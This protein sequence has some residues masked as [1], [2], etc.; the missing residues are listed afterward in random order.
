MALAVRRGNLRPPGVWARRQAGRAIAA[1]TRA[2][3]PR[4]LVVSLAFVAFAAIVSTRTS[5]W[6]R[7]YIAG[8]TCLAI[9]VTLVGGVVLSAE[10]A[11]SRH[12]G[13]DAERF[14]AQHFERLW[15][16]RRG[17]RVFHGLQIGSCDVDHVAVGPGGVL[18]IETKWVGGQQ[19]R[20]DGD[21][22]EGYPGRSP[23]WQA[24]RSAEKVQSFLRSVGDGPPSSVG[25]RPVLVIWG[26]GAPALGDEP[27]QVD[28]V[29]VIEGG[30]RRQWAALLESSG[31]A[32]ETVAT[33]SQ[34]FERYARRQWRTLE[35]TT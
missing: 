22:L 31:L 8:V 7:G 10:S 9:V 15:W 3:W 19:L 17:W 14:T 18:A 4:L 28:G 30:A 35:P 5:G 12:L 32:T 6:T 29:A 23:T 26:P 33:L 24:R 27:V 1:R 16:R 13:A 2:L 20:V 11:L 25:V 34:K 21:R